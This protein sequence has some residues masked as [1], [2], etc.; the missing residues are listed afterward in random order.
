MF[1]ITD[2]HKRITKKV[3]LGEAIAILIVLLIAIYFL[4]T[5]SGSF[6]DYEV[7][8][9]TAEGDFINYY[10]GYWLLPIFKLLSLLSFD[11]SYFLW[12][13]LNV[14]GVFFAAR[15]FNGNSIVALLS[16]QMSYSLY[17]GQIS[18]II[19][20]TLGLFWW[21][22]H[23][24]KLHIAG[25]AIL[26]AAAKPQSGG[27]F[28]FLLWVL[29]KTDWKNKIRTLI[30]PVLGLIASLLLYPGWLLDVFSRIGGAFTWGNITLWQ[31][32]GPFSL[33]LFI[34]FL[35]IRKVDEKYFLAFASACILSIP[36]FLQTDLLTLFIFPIGKIPV[37]LGY[38]PAIM[39]QFLGYNGQRTGVVVPLFIY[40][41]VVIPELY[42]FIFHN[43]FKKNE[44]QEN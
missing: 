5:K 12:I 3:S 37:I 8:L 2:I 13:L 33:I 4:L 30:I 36:Y 20:G 34:P 18:G 24:K 7:Y 16:Y 22:I 11:V 40:L 31:W 29:A 10:Y 41:S 6:W 23:N 15:V 26:I 43:D 38:L 25:F 27:V 19:C 32:V 35:L 14:A 1:E 42:K 9:K 17:W 39:P 21:A 28:V 44:Y